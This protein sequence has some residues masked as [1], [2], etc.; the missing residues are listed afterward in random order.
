MNVIMPENGIEKRIQKGRINLRTTT[1]YKPWLKSG[2]TDRC[3]TGEYEDLVE[4]K[5]SN[6]QLDKEESSIPL[7]A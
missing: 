6:I 2:D 4:L 7:K 5:W 3:V 1:W